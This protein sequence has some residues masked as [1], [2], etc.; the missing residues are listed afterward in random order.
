[1]VPPWNL[2]EPRTFSWPIEQNVRTDDAEEIR[3]RRGYGFARCAR[4][5]PGTGNPRWD[6]T[7]A[8][9]GNAV[10]GPSVVVGGVLGGVAGGVGN[11]FGADQLSAFYD[12]VLLKGRSSYTYA[13]P[14]QSGIIL[15]REGSS[16]R[17]SWWRRSWRNSSSCLRV[18]LRRQGDNSSKSLAARATD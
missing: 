18:V 3:N 4:R 1:M 12:H 6:G 13:E 7:R 11:L 15:P 9:E 10:G 8:G 16:H 17:I 2:P 14:V 5:G